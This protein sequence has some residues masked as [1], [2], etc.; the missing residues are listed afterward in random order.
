MVPRCIDGTAFC[1]V[2]KEPWEE[3]MEGERGGKGKG[4]VGGKRVRERQG[5][6]I[7][8]FFL[9]ELWCVRRRNNGT[10]TLKSEDECH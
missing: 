6:Y 5:N 1:E 10:C 9:Q 8:S 3:E 7:Q 4:R 2:E